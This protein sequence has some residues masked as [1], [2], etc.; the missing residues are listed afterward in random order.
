MSSELV[1][2]WRRGGLN[3]TILV[4]IYTYEYMNICLYTFQTI[5]LM[6]TYTLGIIDNPS[7]TTRTYSSICIYD[8]LTEPYVRMS[9]GMVVY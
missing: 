1:V 2:I 3:P 4:V 5:S 7:S 8:S 6:T 9:S